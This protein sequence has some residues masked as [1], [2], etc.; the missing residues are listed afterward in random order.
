MALDCRPG[1][2][3]LNQVYGPNRPSPYGWGGVGVIKIDTIGFGNID[4]NNMPNI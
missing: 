4:K 3:G 2:G 1:L